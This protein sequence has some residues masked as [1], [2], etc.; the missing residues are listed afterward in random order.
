MSGDPQ[1]AQNPR[2]TP[3]DEAKYAGFPAVKRNAFRG[4][5][6]IARAFVAQV[7]TCLSTDAHG[8]PREPSFN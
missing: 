2:C 5:M 3:G 6:R 8:V 7:M 4:K 1:R